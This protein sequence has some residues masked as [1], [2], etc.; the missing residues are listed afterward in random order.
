[1]PFG[2]PPEV[3]Q[4]GGWVFAAVAIAAI[5][6]LVIGSIIKG[7]LVPGAIHKR[8]VERADKATLQL[9]RQGD[10]LEGIAKDVKAQAGDLGGLTVQL[11]A[12]IDVMSGAYKPGARE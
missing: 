6:S 5:A 8:E 7:A 3:I 11:K 4:A 12:L 10:A 2:L 1:M 9:E